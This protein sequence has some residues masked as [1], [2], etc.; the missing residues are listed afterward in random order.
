MA[1]NRPLAPDPNYP[2]YASDWQTGESSTDVVFRD[3]KWWN[4]YRWNHVGIGRDRVSDLMKFRRNR[5]ISTYLSL[6]SAD[7]GL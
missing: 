2:A 1:I 3:G 7:P 6:Q 4:A 5:A